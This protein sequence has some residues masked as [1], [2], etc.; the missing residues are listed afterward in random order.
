MT[1]TSAVTPG[2]INFLRFWKFASHRSHLSSSRTESH[3]ARGGGELLFSVDLFFRSV[4]CS[5]WR[6]QREA[7]EASLADLTDVHTVLDTSPSSPPRRAT[8]RDARNPDKP[9]AN[10]RT[11]T[12]SKF[13]AL[14]KIISNGASLI[15]AYWWK[16]FYYTQKKKLV[17]T[18]RLFCYV[19]NDL[20]VRTDLLSPCIIRRVLAPGEWLSYSSRRQNS[21]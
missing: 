13:Y 1:K 7:I 2:T 16:D 5:C 14:K 21:I 12:L 11:I 20:A 4:R 10:R 9:S 15:I 18:A 17:G 3:R 8:R 6:V 19:D